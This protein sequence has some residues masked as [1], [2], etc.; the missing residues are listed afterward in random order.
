MPLPGR[1]GLPAQRM[2]PPR[3]ETHH[4]PAA[5]QAMTAT[6]TITRHTA[7]GATFDETTGRSIYPAAATVYTGVCRVQRQAQQEYARDV[8]DRQV[9]IRGYTVSI[10]TSADEVR[11]GDQVT[12]TDPDSIDEGDQH[13]L[14]QPLWVHD[15]RYGSLTWQRDFVCLNAPPTG[16]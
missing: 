9:V 4:R 11:I 1:G 10:P 2:I 12:V 16:R 5:E 7:V 15:I 3:W 6:C 8:G 14:G 13:L